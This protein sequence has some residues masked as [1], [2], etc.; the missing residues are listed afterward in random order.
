MQLSV[1][2]PSCWA[3]NAI[4]EARCWYCWPT[5]AAAVSS[6]APVRSAC[7]GY[8]GFRILSV[9]S[10]RIFC[11]KLNIK[12]ISHFCNKQN[13][14]DGRMETVL[15]TI[16]WSRVVLLKTQTRMSL[17]WVCLWRR[18]SSRPRNTWAGIR[19]LGSLARRSLRDRTASTPVCPIA[20]IGVRRSTTVVRRRTL[21]ARRS[22]GTIRT[23]QWTNNTETHNIVQYNIAYKN[24]IDRNFCIMYRVVKLVYS[25]ALFFWYIQILIFFFLILKYT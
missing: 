3:C 19:W 17:T 11:K 9:S 12:R 13:A 21:L 15:V 23:L 22:D 24:Y 10:L 20:S 8:T 4:S 7:T 25:T 18:R 14:L 1:F 6:P 16:L 2:N 5:P